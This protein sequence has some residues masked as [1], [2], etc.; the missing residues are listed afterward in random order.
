[1]V[2]RAIFVA[3]SGGH[4]DELVQLRPT[5]VDPNTR[6]TWVTFDSAHSR[7]LLR[8]E[9][10]VVF[11]G[12]V[13]PRGYRAVI[14][15]L[16]PALRILLRVRP[17]TVISTG[18]AV[19]LAF[20]PFAF[21]VG[22]RA[23]YIE[24]AARTDGP[25]AT[26]RLLRLLPWVR[27]RTQY[28]GWS[29]PRW[30]Y[31][32]SV[33]DGL[34]AYDLGSATR[35]PIRR[36]V[37]T[38]G[39]QPR[40]PFVSLV[41]RVREIAPPDVEVLWQVGT[42]FPHAYRPD[43]AHDLLPAATLADSIAKADAVI[44]HGGVGSAL[45]VLRAGRKPVLVARRAARHEHVDDHQVQL[46]DEL[47][48]RDLAVGASVEDLT[49][50]H[51]V[52]STRAVVEPS[53]I[54]HARQAGLAAAATGAP[55]PVTVARPTGLRRVI[56]PVAAIVT[57]VGSG[58]VTDSADAVGQ[59][60][61]QS[62]VES[63]VP[64]KTTP[65]VMDGTVYAINQVGSQIVLGGS[66]TSVQNPGSTTSIAR[67]DALSFDASTGAVSTTF[68]P[69][70]D[71]TVEAVAP[72]PVANTVYVGGFFDNVNGAKAKGI[73]LLNATTGTMVPGFKPPSLNGAVETIATVNGHLLIGGSFSTVGGQARGGIAS[74]N[75][76]TGAV[77]SYLTVTFAGHHNY[78][79]T[80]AKGALGARAMAVNPAGTRLAVL[81]NF[82]TANGLLRDQAAMIDLSA[83]G[84]SLDSWATTQFS[85]PCSRNSFDA[86][87]TDV[88]F[89]PDGS[90]FAVTA[91]GGGTTTLNVDGS[92]SLCDTASRW[93]A[94]STSGSAM[95]TWVDY[96][97]NDT[98]W[99]V[100]VTG[101]AIYVGGH[102]RWLNN[103]SGSDSSNVGAV[104]R[105]GL[106][107]LDPLSGLPLAWNP[108]RNPRGAGAYALFV[109]AN[110]LY[111][112]SDT[113]FIG[114]FTYT[115]RKIAYFPLA[116]GAAPAATT[117]ASL[118]ANVYLDG[119]LHPESGF[120]T[121][122]LAYRAVD[123]S[124]V[125]PT[126]AVAS[127]GIN[128]SETRGAFAVGSTLFF[129]TTGGAGFYRAPISSTTGVGAYA[130]VDPYDDPYWAH[131]HTG[132]GT[133]VYGGVKPTY[134][135]QMPSVTGAF[136][137]N[138][139]LFYSIAGSSSLYW[140]WFSPDS[141]I[142]G[143]AQFTATGFDASKVAGMFAAGGYLYWANSVDGTLHRVQ[144]S[145]TSVVAGTDSVV[146]GPAV[147]GRDWRARSLFAFG[148]STFPNVPPTASA[149]SSCTGLNCSFDGNASHDPD[150]SI[151]SYAWT[152][153]DG[154]TGTGATP[155]HGY[156][157]PGTYPV[158]LTVTDNRAATNKWTG[159]VTVTAPSA[160][161]GFV[162]T[163]GVNNL[164]SSPSV[165][166]PPGTAAG[167][168]ELLY[169]TTA[170]NGLTSTPAGWTQLAR[171]TAAPLETTVY[172]RTAGASD[173]GS[174]VTVPL[175]A[176]TRVDLRVVVYSGVSAVASASAADSN[177]AKH[178]TP[179]APVQTGG[180][181]VVS[182]WSGRAST[183]ETWSAPSGVVV[184]G[185]GV[186]TG[187]G[188]VDSL[189]AD[190]GPFASGEHGSLTATASTTDGKG[191]TASIV[192]APT[193]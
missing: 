80:G 49:W 25:S 28:R 57:L 182:F 102:Q 94:S 109:N 97:G 174:T 31:E 156:A 117:T 44:A 50:E 192:L 39:T 16:I 166:L 146:G 118:P 153:G 131:V 71:G 59:G 183:A 189:I 142:I 29:G 10:D 61:P 41:R 17:R 62:T 123:G 18:A 122:S 134:Y 89:S 2:S 155:H 54:A 73:A 106:A 86:Y 170:T 137:S 139:R 188:H 168:T 147:D 143:G 164:S 8:H 55:A 187:G 127:S 159:Q 184:R 40:Y 163:A 148:A 91:T 150:G 112:G 100:A 171:Q 185:T 75:P 190:A 3:S 104:P 43:G 110:G 191:T 145:G 144:L 160:P 103:P 121:S 11:I 12:H 181:W 63:V 42:D 35:R 4:L 24:S 98:L 78:N 85:A 9:A 67:T 13:G 92:R 84:T 175:S 176:S 81:G 60:N 27:L 138:G 151:A 36:V 167:N 162:G 7:S 70:L 126:T 173:A 34:R 22:A 90:Y 95:P 21:L 47:V 180:S 87:V 161:V 79:G 88:Q 14:R 116:G 56:V 46:V 136:Y 26:G 105:P 113:D 65:N 99:S 141:G 130:A 72:G 119:P 178:V 76:S 52:A 64:T 111:V 120:T 115:R 169:V 154:T 140:R 135:S 37:V 172:L 82:K 58:A 177:T 158:S 77:D 68:A 19:A 1:M 114:N 152:F 165:T 5:L 23:T 149:T 128:W 74:L 66:F 20:L 93:D 45:S 108:G 30:R 125:G 33:F 51:V 133:S 15:S 101:A 96:T 6:V 132:S 69:T 107:A 179:G 83:T 129:G 157:T 53:E 124:H 38:L 48:G 32:C 186:G 193:A